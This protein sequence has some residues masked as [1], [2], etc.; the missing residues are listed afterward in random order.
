MLGNRT[1]CQDIVCPIGN[2]GFYDNHAVSYSAISYMCGYMRYHYPAEYATAYLNFADNDDDI[3]TG[4]ALLRRYKLKLI[5]PKYGVTRSGYACNA[6]TKEITQGLTSIKGFGSDQGDALYETSKR[7]HKSF[8]DVLSDVYT[9]V[10]INQTLVGILID[11]DYFSDFGTQP[12]LHA[13]HDFYQR[14]AGAKEIKMAKFEGDF[15]QRFRDEVLEPNCDK[16]NKNGELRK[17]WVIIDAD[18]LLIDCEN[19][20]RK[21]M[22]IADVSTIGKAM[23]YTEIMGFPGYVSGRNEDRNLLYVRDIYPIKRKRDGKQF[24]FSFITK[25]LGSGIESRFSV[26]LGTASRCG[27]ISPGEY[28]RCNRWHNE[29]G[30]FTMDDYEQLFP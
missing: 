9:N 11:L 28:I 15:Y 30:Y 8:M 19:W 7:P 23:R 24:G 21:T 22:K 18:Q 4:M 13:I 5:P 29:N 16:F 26:M 17:S 1:L 3:Q 27:K 2:N 12:V 20:V 10:R 6:S 14:F 25:S